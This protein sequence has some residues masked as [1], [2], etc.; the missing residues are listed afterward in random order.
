M[1]ASR[2]SD[3]S[4]V[5]DDAQVIGFF[6]PETVE[7]C[8]AEAP[9]SAWSIRALCRAVGDDNPVYRDEEAAIRHGHG[10]IVAP[11]VM[12]HGYTLPGLIDPNRPSL[13]RALR[14]R[15]AEHG[16]TS[17]AAVNYTQDYVT[18]IRLGD[19]LT[20]EMRFA[21][22]SDEKTTGLGAGHFCD[23]DERVINQKGE[24]IGN[25]L[26]RALF[27]RPRDGS[28]PPRPATPKAASPAAES[29][30]RVE[31]PSLTI[32]ITTTLIVAAALATND[33]EPVH[34]DRDAANGQGMRDVFMNILTSSA[35]ATR[36]VTD[37]TGPG[38]RLKRLSTRLN[39]PN[40]PGDTMTLTGWAE[41]PYA[42]GEELTVHVRGSN[43]L[44]THIDCAI[45]VA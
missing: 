24:L 38:A 2:R 1:A 14:A 30:D 36:L 29:G 15:L 33:F 7:I 40:F 42:P 44:G 43:S 13:Q 19:V 18:P 26:I 35:L 17:V 12:M 45:T 25:Q 10:G 8:P 21:N 20:R 5:K 28:E 34:H 16:V 41:K 31:L 4:G 37:W 6:D 27:F 22:L 23:F 11:P 3:M 39:A 32:P 9:V